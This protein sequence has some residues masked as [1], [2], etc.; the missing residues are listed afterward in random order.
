[1]HDLWRCA[2]QAFELLPE[3]LAAETSGGGSEK[4]GQCFSR[5]IAATRGE[6]SVP[7]RTRRARVAH[8]ACTVSGPWCSST[9]K[10]ATVSQRG[11]G[12]EANL[13]E[14]FGR[15]GMVIKAVPRPA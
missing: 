10:L 8:G 3:G 6:R 2:P 14:V 15:E 7:G 5:H 13:G 9:A 11:L 1:M 12:G 4:S